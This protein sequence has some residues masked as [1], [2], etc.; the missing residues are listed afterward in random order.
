M[1]NELNNLKPG[2]T[3]IPDSSEDN[4]YLLM[5]FWEFT[6]IATLFLS[7]FP[8]SL[9]ICVCFLGIEDTKFL[10]LA[11]LH[12]FVKTALTVLAIIITLIILVVG[13]II[14]ASNGL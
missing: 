7:F 2:E 9:L 5:G 1:S 8:L 3:T 4:K 13:I 12:D 14:L 6:I 10:V 11:L